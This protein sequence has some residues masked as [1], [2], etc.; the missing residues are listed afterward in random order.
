MNTLRSQFRG[1]ER[2][3]NL[4]AMK[5]LDHIFGSRGYISTLLP[6]NMVVSCF[7]FLVE[8]ITFAA[9]VKLTCNN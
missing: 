5:I 2:N 6:V 7:R 9:E 4:D 3:T 8:L 1:A